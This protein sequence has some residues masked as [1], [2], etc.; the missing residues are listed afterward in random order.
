MVTPEWFV[1][2]FQ[3]ELIK[4]SITKRWINTLKDKYN[5]EEKNSQLINIHINNNYKNI[6]ILKCKDLEWHLL[7]LI[8]HCH[9]S[10]KKYFQI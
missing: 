3:V 5:I 1:T 4:S 2:C 6:Q 10:K 7:Q 9:S 8:E